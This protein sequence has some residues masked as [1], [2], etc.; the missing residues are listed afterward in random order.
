M[1]STYSAY[2]CLWYIVICLSAMCLAYLFVGGQ[3]NNDNSHV[4][5]YFALRC[6]NGHASN[7]RIHKICK[8]Q[9]LSLIHIITFKQNIHSLLCFF[10]LYSK[11]N[12]VFS[13]SQVWNH[14]FLCQVLFA[15]QSYRMVI[16]VRWKCC[17]NVFCYVRYLALSDR[18]LWYFAFCRALLFKKK[19]KKRWESSCVFKFTIYT[20]RTE[21]HNDQAY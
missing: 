13:F 4:V 10:A 21:S 11:N 20:I 16:P 2:I 6:C 5:F 8:T 15:F 17:W 9:V 7:F 19:R 12:F 3:Y 18:L 14:S 1:S